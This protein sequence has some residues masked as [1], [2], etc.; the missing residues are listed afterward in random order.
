MIDKDV[1]GGVT[2]GSWAPGG[3]LHG[4]GG[5]QSLAD[6]AS[7]VVKAQRSAKKSQSAASIMRRL[8][9]PGVGAHGGGVARYMG[10]LQVVASEVGREQMLR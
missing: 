9:M 3:G 10:M 2:F 5:G 8:S 4:A 6:V 7:S 1:S